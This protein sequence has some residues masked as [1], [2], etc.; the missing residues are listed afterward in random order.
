M[1][2]RPARGEPLFDTTWVH[3][4]EEDTADGDVYRPET[5]DIPL[6]RRPRRRLTLMPDGTARIGV[7]GPDDRPRD[8]NATWRQEGDAIVV[9][10]TGSSETM[11]VTH[12]SPGRIIV[13]K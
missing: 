10:P 1:P 12:Q 4:F 11:R 13:R 9:S 8:V 6:S 2:D 5:S 3:V 7:P